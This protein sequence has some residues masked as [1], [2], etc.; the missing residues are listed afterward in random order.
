MKKVM[1]FALA[2]IVAAGSVFAGGRGQQ[3]QLIG[4]AMPETHVDRW[5]G[6]GNR[7]RDEAVRRGFRAEVMWADANQLIQNTHVD[8]FLTQGADLI[9]IGAVNEGAAAAV[10]NAARDGVPV[11][12]YDR[13]IMGT[14]DIDYFITFNNYAVG[15]AQGQA[16]VDAL[17]LNA[18]TAANPRTITLF[19]GSPTDP[20]AFFF[21]DGAMSVLLPHIDRGAL[22]VV[23]PSPRSHSDPAFMAIAT[24]GWMPINARTRMDDLLVGAA[25]GTIVLDAILSP[26][27]T[28]ARAII[29]SLRLDD[30][31]QATLPVV[32]GQ[33][34]EFDS[35]ISIWNGEQY[36]TIFK[37]THAL[38]EAAVLLAYQILNNQPRNIPGATIATGDLAAIGDTGIRQVTTF[39]FDITIIT[40]DNIHVPL[41]AQFFDAAQTAQLRAMFN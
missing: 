35:L 7:L 21:F 33:D 22:Q 29:E 25:G 28:L 18:V 1:F 4:I 23:G 36:M 37:D 34:S 3:G 16:I 6:D 40:R 11:I 26:N 10:A 19:A 30:R 2:L 9:I 15:V 38:A 5:I 8:S 41:D 13:L 39:L 24:P 27:D 17:D 12:A 20:N 32:T 14:G 31:Y